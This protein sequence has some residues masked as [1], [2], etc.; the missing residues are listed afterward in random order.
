MIASRKRRYRWLLAN[1]ASKGTPMKPGYESATG[2]VAE[3]KTGPVDPDQ[4][5]RYARLYHLHVCRTFPQLY[6][7]RA[8]GGE[9]AVRLETARD[10][11]LRIGHAEDWLARAT[12]QRLQT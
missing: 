2:D 11:L 7:P 8:E 4:A 6:D 5:A 1:S 10:V 12:R 3:W 9:G